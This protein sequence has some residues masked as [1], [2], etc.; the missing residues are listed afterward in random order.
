MYSR[1]LKKLALVACAA[2]TPIL[3]GCD[4]ASDLDRSPSDAAQRAV[5]SD[6]LVGA[7]LYAG[8]EL[9][10]PQAIGVVGGWVLVSDIPRPHA[11]HVIDRATGRYLA[12]WGREGKG[13]GEFLRVWGI[14]GAAD[15]ATAWLYDPD[16][17]RLTH[18]DI[19][20][21][22]SGSAE[23]HRAMVNLV[24][25][26][27]PMTAL[28]LGDSVIV[29]SGIFTRGRLAYFDRN[30]RAARTAGPLP[31]ST[32]GAPVTVAQHAYSGTMVRHPQGRRLAIL[33]RHADRIEIYTEDGQPVRVSRGPGAFDPAYEVRIRGNE[34]SMATGAD[35]RF[36]YVEGTAAGEHI[37]ALYSGRTRGERGKSHFGGEVHVFDWEGKLLRILPLD[38][39]ALAITVDPDER[40]LYTIRHDPEPAVLRYELP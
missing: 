16:Q 13:P 27:V 7:I 36:G 2:A 17:S 21:L 35:L 39:R 14:V 33:T 12:G 38:E 8:E 10:R 31:P 34:P 15:G 32:S 22:V 30:G 25:D 6:T 28:W 19:G 5:S 24:G 4:R 26:V 20:A 9:G 1:A 40:T 11:L 23:P 29:S 37:Y 18:V 3:V